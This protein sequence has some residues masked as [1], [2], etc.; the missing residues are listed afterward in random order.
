MLKTAH[1]AIIHKA[2][3]EGCLGCYK[4][5]YESLCHIVRPWRRVDKGGAA[6]DLHIGHGDAWATEKITF[7]WFAH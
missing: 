3:G 7:G 4:V 5:R 1:F 2:I 6:E